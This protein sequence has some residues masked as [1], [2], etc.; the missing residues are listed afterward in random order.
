MPL[1]S[2]E[3]VISKIFL[4][5]GVKVMLDFDLAALYGTETK[6]LKRAVRR[7]SERFPEDFMFELNDSEI[8]NLRCQIGTSSWGGSRYRPMAFT[9]QGVA[10]LSSILKSPQAVAV[11]IQIIRVF[12]RMRQLLVT[13][14][15]ILLKLEA[16]EKTVGKH[17]RDFTTV[18]AYLRELLNPPSPAMRKIGF[19]QQSADR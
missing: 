19:Q 12:T 7:N 15:N 16:L 6:Q 1:V 8:E 9:E 10:M 18:F 3:I 13:Q 11:N 4:L 5:R 17:N 2:D 14:K